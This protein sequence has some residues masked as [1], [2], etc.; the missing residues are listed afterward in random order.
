MKLQQLKV[1]KNNNETVLFT[2]DQFN[3]LQANL[4]L[5]FGERIFLE[6]TAPYQKLKSL[7]PNANIVICSSS[8]QISNINLVQNNLVATAIA[9]EK[10]KIRTTEIDILLN[11]DIKLL[12]KKIKEDLGL[13]ESVKNRTYKLQVEKAL[14]DILKYLDR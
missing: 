14:R 13:K 8:G 3:S 2:T 6:K 12:G 9:F 4:V 1:D 5:A 7:Y 11:P 10:T